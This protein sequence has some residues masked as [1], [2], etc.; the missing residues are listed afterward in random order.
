MLEKQKLDFVEMGVVEST[1]M[2]IELESPN[3]LENLKTKK[4]QMATGNIQLGILDPFYFY[5]N[6]VLYQFLPQMALDIVVVTHND[7][8]NLQEGALKMQNRIFFPL[9]AMVAKPG[10]FVFLEPASLNVLIC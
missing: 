9:W 5:F 8:S 6:V 3:H 4:T 1:L 2:K 7:L 10:N